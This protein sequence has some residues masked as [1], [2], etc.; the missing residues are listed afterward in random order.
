M[1]ETNSP[2]AIRRLTFDSASTLPSAVSNVS[3]TLRT[4][5][6]RR[7][8]SDPGSAVA[9]AVL[10]MRTASIGATSDSRPRGRSVTPGASRFNDFGICNAMGK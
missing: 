4:S 6:A 3:E 9:S 5:I 10:S 7:C 1:K 8:G 2:S